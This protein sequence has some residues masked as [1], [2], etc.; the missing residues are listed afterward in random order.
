MK[1]KQIKRGLIFI[2]LVF[3]LIS[4]ARSNEPTVLMS[5]Y[6]ESMDNGSASSLAFTAGDLVYGGISFNHISST[7]VIQYGNRKTIVPIYIFMG[8]RAPWKLSP[9]IEA[10]LDLPE[11][12]IDDTINNEEDAI[13]MTDYYYSG[14]LK[15]SIGSQFSVSLYAK[16]YN[17]IF[18]NN[19]LSPVIKTRPGSYGIGVTMH[20]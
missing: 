3:C 2:S 20:F 10:G 7:T 17:F 13:N 19:Y 1:H 18:R 5:I 9:Y 8:F 12:I 11:A 16:K 4:H 6:N 14:G 15:F